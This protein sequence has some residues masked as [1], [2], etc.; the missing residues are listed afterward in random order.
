MAK[1][2]LSCVNTSVAGQVEAYDSGKALISP[3]ILTKDDKCQSAWI[4]SALIRSSLIRMFWSQTQWLTK[5]LIHTWSASSINSPPES[6]L[7]LGVQI[8]LPFTKACCV[9]SVFIC[10]FLCVTVSVFNCVLLC[11]TPALNIV[12]NSIIAIYPKLSSSDVTE[13]YRSAP[14]STHGSYYISLT[15]LNIN[16]LHYRRPLR[17]HGA[18][19]MFP[20]PK[21]NYSGLPRR[22]DCLSA[23]ER[24]REWRL[25]D[26]NGFQI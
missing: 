1:R 9:W 21:L 10:N 2:S 3:R 20:D 17:A 18:D 7:Y 14:H 5:S 24:G 13:P 4:I 11:F 16:S 25:M 8:N 19:A 6:H 26:P 15:A 12:S 22:D 23:L